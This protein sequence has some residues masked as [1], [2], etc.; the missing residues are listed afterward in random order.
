MNSKQVAVYFLDKI[1]SLA[2]AGVALF[3]SAGRIDW[4]PA[5]AVIAV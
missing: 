2:A 1:L 3:W 5:W 4:W